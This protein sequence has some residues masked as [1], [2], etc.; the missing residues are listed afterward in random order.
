MPPSWAVPESEEP[1]GCFHWGGFVLASNMNLPRLHP[2]LDNPEVRFVWRVGQS[3]PVP[4]PSTAPH[5]L[6][7]R[8]GRTATVLL[9]NIEHGT[10]YEIPGT[11]TY[12]LDS[13]QS[14]VEFFP[15]PDAPAAWVEYHLVHAVVGLY[16]GL[17][18]EI[19]LHASA[20]ARGEEALIY[21]GP[22]GVGKSTMAWRLLEQGWE[23][24]S[25]DA[26]VIK[27][28]GNG[29]CAMPGARTIRI[30][31]S[32]EDGWES[33]DKWE[34]FVRSCGTAKAV[35]KVVLLDWR[36]ISEPPVRAAMYQSLLALQPAWS[37]GSASTRR[38]LKDQTWQLLSE[39]ECTYESRERLK[40]SQS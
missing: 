14:L 32:L 6:K 36:S 11:G 19:C 24:L 38:K 23:L 29:W 2:S 8:D 30:G 21:A 3:A 1:L 39:V 37:W 22:S 20:V 33:D 7:A 10:Y 9:G 35:R 31:Q 18:G 13:K 16:A 26:V 4:P 28:A 27:R 40:I 34:G 15:V 17:K 5:T 25:D 12:V